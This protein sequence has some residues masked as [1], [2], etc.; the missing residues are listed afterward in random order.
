[1]Y[2]GSTFMKPRLTCLLG[3]AAAAISSSSFADTVWLS[4]LDLT[5]VETGGH[6]APMADK[7]RDGNTLTLGGKKFEHGIG[8]EARSQMFIQLGGGGKHLHAVV[9]VDDDVP[10]DQPA[11]VEFRVMGDHRWLLWS[12]GPMTPG[13]PAKTVDLDLDGVTQLTLLAVDFGEWHDC[14]H[15]DWADATLE[16]SGRAPRTING[17]GP[18]DPL[19]RDPQP[20]ISTDNGTLVPKIQAADVVA[21]QPGKPIVY[22]VPVLGEPP[23]SFSA[24]GLPAGAALDSSSGH[25]DGSFQKPGSY[26]VRVKVANAHGSDTAAI[27]FVVGDDLALTPPIGWNSYDNFGAKVTEAEFLENVHTFARE[28]HPYGWQYV[29]V[30]YLWFDPNPG[31]KPADRQ[32]SRMDAYGRA[33]PALSRFPSA[34]GDNG[35]KPIA[36]QVHTLGLRF[37]IHIMRGIPRDAVRD[38]LPIEGSS[39]HAADAADTSDTCGW[40]DHMYGVRGGTPAGQAYYD[41]IVRLYAQWGVD[42]IKVD[43]ISSP[44]R[45]DEIAAVH[46]A[47]EKC[48]RSIVLSLS[49]G[50]APVAEVVHLR[51]NAQLW[52]ATSDFWDNWDQLELQFTRAKEW[53]PYVEPGHWPDA[54]MLPIGHIGD[55]SVGLPRPTNFSHAEQVALISFWS[56]LPSPLMIGSDLRRSNAWDIALL[57]NPEVLAVNQDALGAAARC[58]ER[59]ASYEVWGRPLHDGSLAVGLFNL[60][61]SDTAVRV[62]LKDLGLTGPRTP[63]DLWRR[64]TLPAVEGQIEMQVKSHGAVLLRL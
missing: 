24:T 8:M 51:A 15:A 25:V 10:A 29:V 6:H 1:L 38:N 62:S 28:L 60:G 35:F 26:A 61:N 16:F 14:N 12:S 33:L 58:V 3:L 31:V 13:Q 27:R 41:S 23:F 64:Q 40:D 63:R 36:D 42:Y 34:A 46:R 56:I 39:Y 37:G 32:P 20:V 19:D 59:G 18:A 50:A 21:F 45:A 54:D 57:T 44:Y 9:G 17:S 43:D 52:R 53:A 2:A 48:S 22:A 5:Q 47:I 55:E 7:S 4:S 49:P 30:D 11:R